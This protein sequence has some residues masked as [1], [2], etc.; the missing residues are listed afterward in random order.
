MQKTLTLIKLLVG[1]VVM[2][3]LAGMLLPALNKARSKAQERNQSA[4]ANSRHCHAAAD[5]HISGRNCLPCCRI[6]SAASV[7]RSRISCGNMRIE[8]NFFSEMIT[9]KEKESG[10]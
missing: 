9:N 5:G 2:A 7:L 1:I 4:T 3:I 6:S 10:V 8:M